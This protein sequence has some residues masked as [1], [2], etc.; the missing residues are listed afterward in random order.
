VKFRLGELTARIHRYID[1]EMFCA[2]VNVGGDAPSKFSTGLNW[3]EESESL[4]ARIFGNMY[5]QWKVHVVNLRNA[6]QGLMPM[7]LG[8]L[9]ELYAYVLFRRGQDV[10]PATL[11][12]LEEGHL[13]STFYWLHK[14]YFISLTLN[15]QIEMPSTGIP[16]SAVW[17]FR[18]F[19]YSFLFYL[20][21]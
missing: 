6:P 3:Q 15:Q 16:V 13:L 1:H 4:V 7:V 18:S 17:S 9:L 2:V 14:F 5:A 19:V 12:V 11:L 8:S 21:I 10:N 20:I